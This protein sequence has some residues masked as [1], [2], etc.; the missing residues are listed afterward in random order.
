MLGGSLPIFPSLGAVRKMHG[1]MLSAL[2]LHGLKVGECQNDNRPF[3]I[4]TAEVYRAVDFA[5]RT[6]Q[7]SKYRMSNLSEKKKA[8]EG[9]PTSD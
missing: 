5:L 4:I 1:E 2:Q 6:S 7:G 8:L 9:N 3:K